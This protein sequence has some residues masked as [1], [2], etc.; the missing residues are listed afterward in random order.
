M[1]S[2]P[3]AAPWA[4][5]STE[6]NDPD[7]N[8]RDP[9]CPVPIIQFGRGFSFAGDRAL[10]AASLDCPV[11]WAEWTVLSPRAKGP[12]M[13]QPLRHVPLASLLFGLGACGGVEFGDALT[14]D[15]TPAQ[16][17]ACRQVVDEEVARQGIGTEQVRRIWYQRRS[18]SQRG[19]T[20]Q[21]AGYEAWVYPKKA[22]SGAMIIELS[23]SCQVRD[24]RFHA[25]S[26]STAE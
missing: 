14:R 25:G 18:V 23:E 24:V 20:R 3:Q 9:N 8:G 6:P 21:G 7:T 16:A 13:K 12:W 10:I 1:R 17:A 15:L 4:L 22:G 19:A 2:W 11:P 26:D 5:A